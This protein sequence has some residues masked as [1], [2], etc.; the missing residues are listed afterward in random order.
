MKAVFQL[1]P[2]FSSCRS[3]WDPELL[4]T[5]IKG[6]LA[7]EDLS[8]IH[9]SLKLTA[10]MLLVSG[11]RGLVLH[12]LDIRNMSVS[13]SRV[14]FQI[15]DYLKTTRPS[16][17]MSELLF[18]TYTPDNFLCVH[19]ARIHY[20]DRTKDIRDSISS[21]F[22]STKPPIKTASTDTLRCWTQDLMAAAGIDLMV[23]SPHS[24]RCTSS[25]KAALKLP[26]ATIF[27]YSWL[28]QGIYFCRIL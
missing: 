23:F 26:L 16:C 25:S 9:L 4:L 24:T 12:L 14:S 6:L 2:S 3:T 15:G 20:L 18:E 8:L 5:Y 21:L 17:H 11:Q 13:D 27:A 28:V 1:R 10:L 7:N 22:L 19:S